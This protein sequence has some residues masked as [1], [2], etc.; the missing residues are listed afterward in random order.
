MRNIVRPQFKQHKPLVLYCQLSLIWTAAF[1]M[2]TIDYVRAETTNRVTF[3]MP[4]FQYLCPRGELE[5]L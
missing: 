4:R 1:E 2:Q 3:Y 5:I